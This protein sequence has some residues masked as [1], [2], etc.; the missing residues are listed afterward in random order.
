M[1][2]M[3]ISTGRMT[4]NGLTA[5]NFYDFRGVW[6]FEVKVTETV[7]QGVTPTCDVRGL[8]LSIG[9]TSIAGMEDST[10]STASMIP[11]GA[12]QAEVPVRPYLILDPPVPVKTFIHGK[13]MYLRGNV[14]YPLRPD[15]G[16]INLNPGIVTSVMPGSM[17]PVQVIG[18][19]IESASPSFYFLDWMRSN[20]GAYFRDIVDRFDPVPVTPQP[21][22]PP[23]VPSTDVSGSSIDSMIPV[24]KRIRPLW[25]V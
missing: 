8:S 7:P 20:P 9:T 2:A 1:M 25:P 5:D 3:Q 18:L 16:G 24:G 12:Y 6:L 21:P 15:L 22:L 10:T 17:N 23:G 11:E 19:G 14:P 13:N 4:I